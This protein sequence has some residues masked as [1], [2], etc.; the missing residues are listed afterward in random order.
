M[1]CCS[2]LGTP[3]VRLTGRAG[4]AGASGLAPWLPP[5]LQVD[6]VPEKG[7]CLQV[8][9]DCML[10]L[11]Q[12]ML[13]ARAATH[14]P[15]PLF[16]SHDTVCTGAKTKPDKP[17]RAPS[18]LILGKPGSGKTTVLREICRKVSEDQV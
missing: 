17:E 18:I 7:I 13:R 3:K 6:H 2:T 12:W 8:R 15:D 11:N 10:Y 1:I 9:N 4:N 5:L 16:Y 14:D